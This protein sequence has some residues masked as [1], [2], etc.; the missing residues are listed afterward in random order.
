MVS[1]PTTPM[2]LLCNLPSLW[3]VYLRQVPWQATPGS[4]GATGPLYGVDMIVEA[5]RTGDVVLNVHAGHGSKAMLLEVGGPV[6]V[7]V[8]INAPQPLLPD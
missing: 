7:V 8:I 5:K 6:L 3:F 4:E 1:Q 2:P